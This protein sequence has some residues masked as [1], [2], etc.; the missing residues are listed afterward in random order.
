MT[1]SV[2]S[3]TSVDRVGYRILSG[4]QEIL[5]RMLQIDDG[6]LDAEMLREFPAARLRMADE[7]HRAQDYDAELFAQEEKVKA[8]IANLEDWKAALVSRRAALHHHV[9]EAIR[10]S[11]GVPFVLPS[12]EPVRLQKNGGVPAL[13][14]TLDLGHKSVGKILPSDCELPSHY[15][16]TVTYLTLDTDAVRADIAGGASLIWASLETGQHLRGFAL[17]PLKQK[18][19]E[20]RS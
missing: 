1:D 10:G 20:A 14:L 17:K 19:L 5:S 6:E 18:D 16:K 15:L 12:G 9:T 13:K 3:R 7:L 4:A 2:P 11:P 8:Q